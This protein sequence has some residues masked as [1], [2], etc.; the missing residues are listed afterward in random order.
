MIP[1]AINHP[2]GTKTYD[3]ILLRYFVR[4]SEKR[5]SEINERLDGLLAAMA[6]KSK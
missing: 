1:F 4:E 3:D 5:I 2:Q 6:G